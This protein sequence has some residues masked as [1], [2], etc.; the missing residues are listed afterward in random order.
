LAERTLSREEARAF[1][2]RFGKKQDDQGF[3]EDPATRKLEAAAAFE[4]ARFVVELGCGTGR[5]AEGL[6]KRKLPRSSRYLGL[7]PSG[8]M[9]GLAAAR[10]SSW[11]DRAE[12]R[13]TDGAPELGVAD[14]ECDRVVSNYVLDLLSREDIAVFEREAHRALAP[15]G[16]LCLVGLT[17][18]ERLFP[19]VISTL[20]TAVH[21]VAPSKVGGCR[22]LHI[23]DHLPA[24]RWSVS[25]REVVATWGISSEVLI[26]V[27]R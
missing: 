20:W 6:L 1:Y 2:D 18:G 5:F 24:E 19:K 16:R 21:R 14:H 4:R 17:F 11:S 10:L 7:D 13:Q 27:P 26:A 9:I 22:P 8:T 23:A 15:G 3:Y 12:V 25:H